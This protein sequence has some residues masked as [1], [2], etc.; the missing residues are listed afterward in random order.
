MKKI[1]ILVTFLLTGCSIEAS[2]AQ[3]DLLIIA[4]RGDS[5]EA[6]EHTMPA[7]KK[8]IESGA[9]YIEIDLMMSKDGRL[10][11]L[12]DETIDRTTNGKGKVSEYTLKQLKEFDAGAWFSD[13]FKGEK[14]L[15]LEEIVDEFGSSTKYYIE[16]KIV[17]NQSGMEEKLLDIL[18]DRRLLNDVVIQSFSSKSLKRI[19]RSKRDIPL[20]QLC[21]SKDIPYLKEQ[22]INQYADG[23][24]LN[25]R[26]VD[27]DFVERMHSANLEVHT[28]FNKENEKKIIKGVVSLGVDGV[29]TD[30]LVNAK[31]YR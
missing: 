29:L 28:F 24:G 8:A 31:R 6:P 15:S 2:K 5:S 27:K 12:H 4:H 11:A 21:E 14:I 17:D 13:E 20:I 3:D 10:V 7:Y 1:L 16:T 18:S 30:Y 26:L 22:E 9:D 25:G 19:H 23:I